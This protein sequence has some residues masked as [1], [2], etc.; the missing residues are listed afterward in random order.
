MMCEY[1]SALYIL[2][3]PGLDATYKTTGVSLLPPH[4]AELPKEVWLQLLVRLHSLALPPSCIL[5]CS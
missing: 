5:C 1:Q 4:I 3:F 2:G